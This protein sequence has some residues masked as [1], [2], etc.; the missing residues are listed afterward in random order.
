M[1]GVRVEMPTNQPIVLL[2]ERDGGRYLPIWIGAAE[3][4]AITYAQQGVVPPRPLTH[5][6][7]RDVL[8]VLGHELT[9][10]R[11]VALKDSVFHAALI[12][13]GKVEISSRASDAIALA[14]RTGSKVLVEPSILDEAAIVVSSEEDDEVERFKEFLDHV[15]AEDFEHP[16][17]DEPRAGGGESRPEL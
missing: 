7:L 11:I 4:A 10:V 13:D 2:R 12:I 6:L 15:S 3:A 1:L 14:L 9:E 16:D 17:G 8:G 5:D